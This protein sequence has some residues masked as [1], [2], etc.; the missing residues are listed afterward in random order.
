MELVKTS[1]SKQTKFGNFNHCVCSLKFW[2]SLNV[3]LTQL[4]DI[5]W[6]TEKVLLKQTV[7]EIET[8]P[9]QWYISS[10]NRT[11]IQNTEGL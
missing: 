2:L 4:M 6:C 10:L 8:R 9:H 7:D 5:P 3:L 11:K 1:S